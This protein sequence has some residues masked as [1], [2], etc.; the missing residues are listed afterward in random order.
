MKTNIF[1]IRDKY[2]D[3]TVVMCGRKLR[4]PNHILNILYFMFLNFLATAYEQ[5]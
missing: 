3:H 4:K 2:L 5:G 1:T